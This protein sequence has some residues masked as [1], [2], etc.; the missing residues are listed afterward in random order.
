M[1]D[2]T[3]AEA[4]WDANERAQAIITHLV[5]R[6]ADEAALAPGWEITEAVQYLWS[7]THVR[8]YDDLVVHHGWDHDQFVRRHVQT[9]RAV[10]LSEPASSAAR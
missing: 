9:L 1:T 8:A 10:L 7:I 3:A 4:W 5:E 6:L 2:P